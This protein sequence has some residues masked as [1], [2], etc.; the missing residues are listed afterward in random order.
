MQVAIPPEDLRGSPL[1][2]LHFFPAGP[3]AKQL[4]EKYG[5]V[6]KFLRLRSQKD[7]KLCRVVFVTGP[8]RLLQS[9][10]A[11]R[12]SIYLYSLISDRGLYI[13][14]QAT[15]LE[16]MFAKCRLASDGIGALN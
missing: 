12:Q 8:S 2:T 15:L 10:Y 16:S 6:S 11:L 13:F 7:T 1:L 14:F 5:K 9:W 3:I 4:E